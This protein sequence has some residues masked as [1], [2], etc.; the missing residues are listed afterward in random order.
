MSTIP[1]YRVL[2]SA[3]DGTQV[4]VL[5]RSTEPHP[6]LIRVLLS[7]Y[8]PVNLACVT[9]ETFKPVFAPPWMSYFLVPALKSRVKKSGCDLL[10]NS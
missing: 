9:L 2:C 8:T 4:F 7:P 1:Q 5:A 6:Q 10:K 3:G